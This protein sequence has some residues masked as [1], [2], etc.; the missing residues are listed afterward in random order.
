MV[1]SLFLDLL[2]KVCQVKDVSDLKEVSNEGVGAIL[3]WV[4]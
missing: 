2:E 1:V 3:V 4:H